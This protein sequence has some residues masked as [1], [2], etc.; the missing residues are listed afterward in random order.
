LYKPS[1]SD[2]IKQNYWIIVKLWS[3]LTKKQKKEKLT[4]KARVSMTFEVSP[5]SMQ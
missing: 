4:S 1:I 2:K 3:L 5:E